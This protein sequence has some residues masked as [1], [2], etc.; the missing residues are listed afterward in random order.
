[1]RLSFQHKPVEL[2][3]SSQDNVHARLGAYRPAQEFKQ[4]ADIFGGPIWF[5]AAIIARL[6]SFGRGFALYELA[7]EFIF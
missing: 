1:M 4:E 5:L 7:A 6:F 2:P 3:G